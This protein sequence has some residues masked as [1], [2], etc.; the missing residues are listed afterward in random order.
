MTNIQYI[1]SYIYQI[2]NT[3]VFSFCFW[4]HS[5]CFL[6]HRW[7]SELH[8]YFTQSYTLIAVTVAPFISLLLFC[9]YYVAEILKS[10]YLCL[11]SLN[12]I[13]QLTETVLRHLSVYIFTTTFELSSRSLLFSRAWLVLNTIQSNSALYRDL[14]MESLTVPAY[15]DT[16]R[17]CSFIK[18]IHL[19][20]SHTQLY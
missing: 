13:M 3:K 8:L 11:H 5:C 6:R 18:I 16:D 1:P 14:A 7:S 9:S 17:K 10:Y 2:S 12:V 15:R 20:N 4:L 19:F